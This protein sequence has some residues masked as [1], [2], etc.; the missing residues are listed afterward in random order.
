MRS[1]WKNPAQLPVPHPSPAVAVQ[2]VLIY[3]GT[4]PNQDILEA[5][6][7]SLFPLL[8]AHSTIPADGST[9]GKNVGF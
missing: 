1:S 5:G 2:L 3:V 8:A 4:H 6:A 7:S 9:D